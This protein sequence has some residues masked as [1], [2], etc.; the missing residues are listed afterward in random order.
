MRILYDSKKVEFKKPFG[1]LR[2]NEL[3][4][5]NIKI[6]SDCLAHDVYIR[7]VND[8]TGRQ[9]EKAMSKIISQENYDTFGAD[10]FLDEPGL[11]FY[12]FF[13]Q[14]DESN[15][16]L[17][18]F[19]YDDTNIGEGGLWQ[20]TCYPSD[21]SVPESFKGKVM[22]QI[23]PDRFAI[24]QASCTDG[25][26]TP[27]WIHE[28]KKDVPH[29][30]P[31]EHGEVKNC[32]FYGGNLRG[33]I[34][35]LDYIKSLGTSIIYLNPIFMAYSNHR[36]DTCDYKR[37][38][39]MLGNEDDFILLCNEAHKRDIKIILD[40]VFSHTGSNSIYFDKERIFGNG[41]YQNP[42]SPY[43]NWFGF[44][45]TDDEYTSWW[46]IKTLPC[47]N[48][49]EQ[50][51]I[52]YIISGKDSVIA[53]W[54]NLGADGFRLDV[55]DELPDEFIKLLRKRVKEINPE[56]Y[57]VGEVWED[58]SNKI[59]YG[60]RRKY[61]SDSELDSVMNYVFK[62]AIIS[63]CTDVTTGSDFAKE[64]MTIC[65]N[66]P[67]DSLHSLMNSLSTHDTARIL[68]VMSGKGEGLSRNEKS[69]FRL[70]KKDRYEALQRVYVAALLQ[71]ALPGNA[72]IYYGDEIGMEGFGDPFNR[73]FFDWDALEGNNIK[74]FFKE[75]G[76]IKNKYSP[77]KY[78]DIV[79]E[80]CS[81]TLLIFSR[82]YENEKI[83]FVINKDDSEYRLRNKTLLTSHNVSLR[84]EEV[85]IQK[86]G[87][88]AYSEII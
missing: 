67:C 60:V 44:G 56:S 42:E 14:T 37:I 78:G 54:M 6:P 81:D 72:C 85:Y 45:S 50:S 12:H 1:A 22:Y 52:D 88:A 75:L 13:I 55:A 77:L 84:K 57:V 69:V 74:E 2:V 9:S 65:E 66:Y 49:T 28:N 63:Y 27:F 29:Y 3:C 48:E 40:G 73:G 53:H 51:Y 41:A 80:E 34:S 61:F 30:L 5:I 38:D 21:F 43:R 46:G 20:L 17:F 39:P 32:D 4:T 31:D 25:K 18:R 58:A 15:F 82:I 33:I 8:N 16:E 59:S 87:F 26:L 79:F 86:N 68:T 23:F 19:G 35:K 10:F 76:E 11:Y 47:V 70:C 36:Y 24:D 7:F 62:N 83:T 64:I 71:Y